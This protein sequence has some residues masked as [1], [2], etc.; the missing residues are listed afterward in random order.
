MLG[1]AVVGL[2]GTIAALPGGPVR[3][4]LAALTQNH[5]CFLPGGDVATAGLGDSI[6]AGHTYPALNVGAND[7]YVDVLACETGQPVKNHGIP[8][9]TSEQILARVPAVIDSGA[10]TVF[11]L[12]GTNDVYKDKS[13][14]ET[15]PNLESIRA[16]LT[17]AGIRPVFGLLPP[18]N[19][20]PEMV[21]QVNAKVR[22]WAGSKNVPLVD[23][24]TPLADPDGTFKDGFDREGDGLHPG[25]EAS[26][27][28]AEQA[29]DFLNR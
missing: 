19:H 21:R 11:V 17:D 13:T 9:E 10:K 7:S 5:E 24:W 25:P 18:S 4:A 28:M 15:V 1:V 16:A 2:F 26:R 3:P 29:R 14:T 27:L 23:Y 22:A 6:T 20:D 8:G 12:A